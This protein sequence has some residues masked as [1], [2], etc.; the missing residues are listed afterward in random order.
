MKT[1]SKCNLTQPLSNF[2]FRKDTQSHRNECST[3]TKHE[4]AIRESVPGVKELRAVKEKQRRITH[5]EHINSTLWKQRNTPEAK[6]RIKLQMVTYKQNNPGKSS[7]HNHD[8]RIRRQYTTRA[9]NSCTKLEF[10]TWYSTAEQICS[11]CGTTNVK[12]TVD[13]ITP[14]I[15]GGT[16]TTDN[17]TLACGSCN[18]SK[19]GNTLIIW[20][21]KRTNRSRG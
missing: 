1:C 7:A 17:F 18:S 13:H 15:K 8:A 9:E 20:M 2:Y 19:G 4:K 14:L 11:Y 6:E 12:L 16:H 21:A 5:K 3:C 10:M